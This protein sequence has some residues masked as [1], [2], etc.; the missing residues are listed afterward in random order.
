MRNTEPGKLN[1]AGTPAGYI[2]FIIFDKIFLKSGDA[3]WQIRGG[4]VS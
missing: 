1:T 2:M 3:L 4:T